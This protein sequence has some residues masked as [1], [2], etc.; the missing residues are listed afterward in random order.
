MTTL[1]DKLDVKRRYH[2]RSFIYRLQFKFG[3]NNVRFVSTSEEIIITVKRQRLINEDINDL[4]IKDLQYIGKVIVENNLVGNVK[5]VLKP[6]NIIYKI[7][8]KPKDFEFKEKILGKLLQDLEH[9]VEEV[10]EEKR[11]YRKK[12]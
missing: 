1:Y 12:H 4:L 10:E 9:F 5:V 3:N 11:T 7:H 8:V 6:N 2:V